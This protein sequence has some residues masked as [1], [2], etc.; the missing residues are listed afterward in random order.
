MRLAIIGI[1]ALSTTTVFCQQ[2]TMTTTEMA[3]TILKQAD[4]IKQLKQKT[5]EDKIVISSLRLSIIQQAAS[6][7]AK[8]FS[9]EHDDQIK[10]L[11]AATGMRW[12]DR[13]GKLVDI[14]TPNQTPQS[15]APKAPAAPSSDV[16][17]V[18]PE[19]KP[20]PKE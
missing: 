13:Q 8:P 3:D 17:A 2:K 9:K 18:K 14:P 10:I 19:E 16:P 7:M 11:E 15:G 12:D 6:S 5:I 4:E 20:Q 1:L